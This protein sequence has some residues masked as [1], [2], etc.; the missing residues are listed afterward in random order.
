M[1][2][3]STFLIPI[4]LLFFL[5]LGAFDSTATG[6]KDFQKPA[7]KSVNLL[8]LPL[9]ERFTTRNLFLFD[10]E[11]TPFHILTPNESIIPH[12]KSL[13]GMK[14]LLDWTEKTAKISAVG[15][16]SAEMLLYGG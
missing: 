5:F 16:I 4:N 7:K 12:K 15:I 6:S 14:T 11:I 2:K 1:K 8:Y 9:D 3:I 13:P 10:A